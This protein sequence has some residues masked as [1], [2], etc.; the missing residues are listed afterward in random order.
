MTSQE[1]ARKLGEDVIERLGL[2]VNLS[3]PDVTLSVDI[4]S[5]EA[6]VY[7]GAPE[8]SRAACPSA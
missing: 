1:L 5:E 6:L 3:H 8:G 7:T 2:G 4:I